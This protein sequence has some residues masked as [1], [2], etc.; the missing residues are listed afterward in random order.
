M[1]APPE[2]AGGAVSCHCHSAAPRILSDSQARHLLGCL[3]GSTQLPVRVPPSCLG[4][5]I[6]CCQ[7][8]FHTPDN[9]REPPWRCA[10]KINKLLEPLQLNMLAYLTETFPGKNA[11]CSEQTPHRGPSKRQCPMM[12]SLSALCGSETGVS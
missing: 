9:K 6:N 2:A 10:R 3:L 5:G 12:Q 11:K 8:S 4:G 7:R 1:G